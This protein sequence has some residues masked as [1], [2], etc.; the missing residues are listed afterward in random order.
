[1]LRHG[2]WSR[3][4]FAGAALAVF[5]IGGWPSAAY[6]E[7]P[8]K[9]SAAPPFVLHGYAE[10]FF[11]W[12]ANRPSN[13][14]TNARGFDNRHA[15]FTLSNVVL[16]ASW[17]A[18]DA[19]GE[20]ALQVGHT[21]STYFLAEPSMPG[22]TA[23][24]ASGAELWK[25]VQQAFAGYRFP[26]LGGLTVTGGIFLSPVGPETMAVRDNWNWSR[27]NLFFGLPFYHTGLR[28]AL[29][30]DD[31]DTLT[32]G[33]VNGWNSVVDTDEGKS[34]FVQW[35]H[36][37]G[38]LTTSLLYFGGVERPPGS[39]EGRPFRHL[40][41]AHVTWNAARWLSVLAHLDGGTEGG[42]VGRSTWVAGALYARIRLASAVHVALREDALYER[43]GETPSG[44]ASPI[45]FGVPWVASRTA[46]LDWHPSERVS[47]RL[48][49]RHDAA[50]GALFFGDE[51][52]TPDDGAAA[53]PQ[54]T[55]QTTA[56]LGVTGGF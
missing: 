28:A 40:L 18:H 47:F 30:L 55:R 32:L 37:R 26:V 10:A 6:A 29:A 12:N 20:V 24:N 33:V 3:G 14:V 34:F 2:L 48:E 22:G 39:P 17:D 49:A 51:P 15:T 31:H 25:Y 8:A 42:L 13:G 46:T 23:A 43:I 41:D 21:P 7:D 1:M 19:V 16:D 54:R 11:Q 4:A 27:S 44:R 52:S 53:S 5:A 56:T 9:P 35:S 38:D 36:A 50:G 45:F